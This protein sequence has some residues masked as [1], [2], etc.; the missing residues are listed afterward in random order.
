MRMRTGNF[1]PKTSCLAITKF[2][3][4]CDKQFVYPFRNIVISILDLYSYS[5]NFNFFIGSGTKY[6]RSVKK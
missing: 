2:E 5:R 6:V 1:D 4:Y 3:N